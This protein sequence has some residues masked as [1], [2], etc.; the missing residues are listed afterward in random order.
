MADAMVQMSRAIRHCI[1][2]NST[3]STLKDVP[4]GALH[5]FITITSAFLADMQAEAERR[6][7]FG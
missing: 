1:E 6:K 5:D 2:D 4:D 7:L 3:G